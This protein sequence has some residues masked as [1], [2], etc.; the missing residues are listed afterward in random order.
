ME[1]TIP[2][3]S[4]APVPF[5]PFLSQEAED[6]LHALLVCDRNT[7]L[8]DLRQAFKQDVQVLPPEFQLEA[9]CLQ[10]LTELLRDPRIAVRLAK[11][12]YK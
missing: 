9:D 12:I 7:A 2:R 11:Y 5:V 3:D 10:V 4:A 1:G 6:E 8:G